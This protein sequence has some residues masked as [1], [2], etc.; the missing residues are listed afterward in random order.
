MSQEE[1]DRYTINELEKYLEI[2][3]KR[4][5]ETLFT[6]KQW[7]EDKPRKRY[8]ILRNDTVIGAILFS[9]NEGLSYKG[10]TLVQDGALIFLSNDQGSWYTEK[11]KELAGYLFFQPL[12]PKK[13]EK[14]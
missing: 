12:R 5:A 6:F 2:R 13:E 9:H 11:G 4:E 8:W 7:N 1:L 14:S 10:A 3:R